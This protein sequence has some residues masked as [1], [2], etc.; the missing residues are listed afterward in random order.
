M[1]VTK[2]YFRLRIRNAADSAN[3]LALSSYPGDDNPYIVEAPSGDGESF[4]PISGAPTTGSYTVR[5]ADPE[6]TT[7]TRVI[8]SQ[9]ADVTARQH[10]IMRKAWVEES[11][12]G[13]TWTT[14]VVGYITGIRLIDA[15]TFEFA[16][17]QSRRIEQSRTVW[18]EVS[19]E[20]PGVTSVIGGP[21]IGGFIADTFLKDWGG[22]TMEV[23]EDTATHTK[24]A[25]TTGFDP[26]KPDPNNDGVLNTFSST[27]TAIADFTNDWA[28]PFFQTSTLY[29]AS[30]IM[31]N[32]PG[33][34]AVLVPTGGGATKTLVPL[35]RPAT[36][37]SGPWW[38]PGVANADRLT[39]FGT[40]Q[41]YLPKVDIDGAAF[42]PAIGTDYYV[43]VYAVDVSEANPLHIYAHPVDLWESLRIDAGIEYD[44]TFLP[45]LKALLGDSLR[46]ALRVATP[47]KLSDADRNIIY[48]PFRLSSR[49]QDG[50][51]VLFSTDTT[52]NAVPTATITLAELRS[53]SGTVFDNDESTVVTDIT[54]KTKRIFK[55]T[56]DDANQP[57]IDSL[58]SRD[59]YPQSIENSDDDIPAGT[60]NDQVIGDIPGMIWDN[61]YGAVDMESFLQ[62]RGFE[63]FERFGRGAIGCELECLPAV[64]AKVGQ[65]VLLDLP[66]M[67]GS[68][69]GQS[70]VTQRSADGMTAHPFAPQPFQIVQRTEN[71]E[72]PSLRLVNSLPSEIADSVL[73]TE[74]VGLSAIEET[75]FA[76][77]S[78]TNAAA[79]AAVDLNVRV[80]T[81]VSATAPASGS[82]THYRTVL[83][84]EMTGATFPFEVGPFTPGAQLW[85]QMRA[86][87]AGM[88]P[89]AYTAWQSVVLSLAPSLGSLTATGHSP[90]V[91]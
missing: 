12:N 16:V 40:S 34:R 25:L 26:R 90:T 9:L 66:H 21:V 61:N 81:A 78:I 17:G 22:W 62:N 13:S 46:L 75:Q 84:P 67:P 45:A 2:K 71:P 88:R 7:A 11:A 52:D 82:G 70:P 73:P 30:G 29:T 51:E 50:K 10:L 56:S 74:T 64:T 48:G 49:I 8:T 53:D 14:L 3:A 55:W 28:R 76:A 15:I 65:E 27:S 60:E 31:G 72:G 59:A 83:H 54:I 68:S 32:F 1:P 37:G 91:A 63:M 38:D 6:T 85:V 39:G 58:I 43:W 42:D 23:D 69:I 47:L 89:G 79:L 20:F 77:V 33:L 4:D 18:K 86:E 41:L 24:L 19:A 87:A 57:D 44:A 36:G 80:D 5:I 35:A